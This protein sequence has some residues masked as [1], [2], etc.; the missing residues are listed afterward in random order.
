MNRRA[1]LL[2]VAIAVFGKFIKPECFNARVGYVF[3]NFFSI[4]FIG[5]HPVHP[6]ERRPGILQERKEDVVQNVFHAGAPGINPDFLEGAHEPRN[7]EMALV[8][9]DVF[10]NVE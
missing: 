6:Q 8:G 5:K 9:A 3:N 1:R 7:D 2:H 10:K 4:L